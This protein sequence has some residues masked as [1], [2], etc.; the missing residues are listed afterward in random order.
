MSDSQF[1]HI[2]EEF[3]CAHCGRHVPIRKKSCRNHCPFCLTSKHVD[4]NPGDRANP[5][6]GLLRAFGY[7]STGHKGL[8]LLFRC[9]KCGQETR[10]IAAN[11]DSIAPDDYDLILTLQPQIKP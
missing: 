3:E 9:E 7:E 4:L 6:Q 10:N 5:C 8:V 2:N 1:T 11:E